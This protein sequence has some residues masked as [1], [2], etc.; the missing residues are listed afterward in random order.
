LPIVDRF[1]RF[2]LKQHHCFTKSWRSGRGNKRFTTVENKRRQTK[3]NED[4]T[5][6]LS[7]CEYPP[8]P[9]PTS[10]IYLA[11]LALSWSWKAWYDSDRV[12]T[13]RS[14]LGTAA[15]PGARPAAY[16]THCCLFDSAHSNHCCVFDNAP[17]NHLIAHIAVTAV[18]LIAHTA[19][20]SSNT[21]D[22]LMEGGL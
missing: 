22:D 8:T 6:E 19:M 11:S 15:S 10:A 1:A 17:S 18:S 5:K 20:A 16:D 13:R 2:T 9:M 4:K 21:A 12:P 7:H 14:C 3:T